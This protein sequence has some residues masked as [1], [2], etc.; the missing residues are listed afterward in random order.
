VRTGV[1]WGLGVKHPPATRLGVLVPGS[2]N[3][4][5]VRASFHIQT[6][7]APKMMPA[8][9]LGHNG[10]GCPATSTSGRITSRTNCAMAI[11]PNTTLARRKKLMVRWND[12]DECKRHDKADQHRADKPF[13]APS[14]KPRQRT[15]EETH[16]SE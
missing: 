7:R 16:N 4:V 8:N 11:R 12:C 15:R 2:F 14:E 3:W 6:L 5:G 13:D 10:I 9:T 1:L